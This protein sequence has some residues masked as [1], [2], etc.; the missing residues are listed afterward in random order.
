L[1]PAAIHLGDQKIPLE[2]IMAK[3][4]RKASR[5]ALRYVTPCDAAVAEV[6]GLL[7]PHRRSH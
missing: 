6:T 5:T 2:L 3:T 7:G 1:V 4:R